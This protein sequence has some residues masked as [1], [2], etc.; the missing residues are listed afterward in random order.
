MLLRRARSLICSFIDNKP[1]LIN[2]L[3]KQ[4]ATCS[5]EAL[6]FL[7]RVDKWTSPEELCDTFSEY[8][9]SSVIHSIWLLIENNFLIVKGTEIADVDEEYEST[10]EWGETTGFYHFGIQNSK[11]RTESETA[12]FLKERMGQKPS[13]P[14]YFRND[15]FDYRIELPSHSK[16][17]LFLSLVASRQSIR[18]FDPLQSISLQS[19]SKCLFSGLRIRDK[20]GSPPYEHPLTMTPSGGAR[21]PYEAYVV[22]QRVEGLQPGSYHYS[23]SEHSLG[24]VRSMLPQNLSFVLA[25]QRW[26]DS[27]AAVVFLVSYFERTMWKYPHP[28]AYRVVLIEAGHIAQNIILAAVDEGIAC[29]PTCAINDSAAA[30]LIFGKPQPISVSVVYAIPIGKKSQSISEK[31]F[32]EIL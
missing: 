27:A 12:K 32:V 28:N 19:L 20:L 21:N 18:E 29:A 22:V 24:Q 2:F 7:A 4:S 6:I 11:W 26:V 14:L 23:A 8:S 3:T 17:D 31:D 10:W 30:E 13:P 5:V 15:E 1:F 9:P 16:E 25:G